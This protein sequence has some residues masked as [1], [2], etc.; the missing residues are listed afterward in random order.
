MIYGLL[1]QTRTLT[2]KEWWKERKST[3]GQPQAVRRDTWG[4]AIPRFTGETMTQ[5]FQSLIRPRK[6]AG[7][8]TDGK[9]RRCCLIGS[10]LDCRLM[11]W[12]VWNLKLVFIFSCLWEKVKNIWTFIIITSAKLERSSSPSNNQKKI[13]QTLYC[14]TESGACLETLQIFLFYIIIHTL[15]LRTLWLN[16]TTTNN[17]GNMLLYISRN[18]QVNNQ[19]LWLLIVN[20][21]LILY[22]L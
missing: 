14:R 18:K 16:N 11:G 9:W 10:V 15:V 2:V 7:S 5:I 17:Q 6:S 13:K 4:I 22:E 8:V 20:N 3:W 1:K 12:G 19:E 21:W